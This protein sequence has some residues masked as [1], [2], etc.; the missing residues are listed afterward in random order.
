MYQDYTQTS[1][2][3][4]LFAMG[5][6]AGNIKKKVFRKKINLF[7]V[8]IK[9]ESQLLVIISFLTHILLISKMS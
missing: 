7:L 9:A 4:L 2:K 5:S 6:K 8:D 3:I 1:V